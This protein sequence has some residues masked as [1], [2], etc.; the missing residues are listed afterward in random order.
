MDIIWSQIYSMHSNFSMFVGIF[1]IIDKMK[2]KANQIYL[3]QVKIIQDVMSICN[4]KI[5]CR[6]IIFVITIFE[7]FSVLSHAMLRSPKL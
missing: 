4:Q 2:S 6:K 1:R 5:N 7:G 3:K